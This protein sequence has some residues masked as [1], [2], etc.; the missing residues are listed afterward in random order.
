MVLHDSLSHILWMITR[1]EGLFTVMIESEIARF[2][3]AQALE[4]QAAQQ[5]LYGF[6]AVADH[7]S[8]TARMERGAE[9]LLALFAEGKH[10]EAIRLWETTAWALEEGICPM[11]TEKRR[12]SEQPTGGTSRL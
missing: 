12:Q 1:K 6:A 3:Q 8:I 10:E 4:E 7:R 9:R 11:M 2:R 5:G